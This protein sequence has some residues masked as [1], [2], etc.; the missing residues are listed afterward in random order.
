MMETPPSSLAGIVAK[1]RVGLSQWPTTRPADEFDFHE[2]VA[3][4][5]MTD[6]IRLIDGG[7]HEPPVPCCGRTAAGH[8]SSL[9]A[10]A[11]VQLAAIQALQADR[12]RPGRHRSRRGPRAE[13]GVIGPRFHP[14]PD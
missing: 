12:S 9:S 14:V 4:A 5:F 7:R 8:T 3:H 13:R 6:A 1:F 11:D 10:Q 2:D